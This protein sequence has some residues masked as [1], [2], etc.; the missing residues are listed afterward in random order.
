MSRR[1]SGSFGRSGSGSSHLTNGQDSNAPGAGGQAVYAVNPALFDNC[2]AL[3]NAP[4][5]LTTA[6]ILKVLQSSAN[7]TSISL[8]SWK[9]TAMTV[10]GLLESTAYA[11]FDVFFAFSGGCIQSTPAYTGGERTS[12]AQLRQESNRAL[13]EKMGGTVDQSRWPAASTARQVSLPGLLVFLLCQLFVER[14]RTTAAQGDSTASSSDVADYVR[15]HLH[16]FVTAV[17]VTRASRLTQ[18]DA[19]ELGYL[20]REVVNGVE[21]PFGPSVSFLWQYNE[22]TIDVAVLSQ[23]LRVRIRPNSEIKRGAASA[24]ANAFGFNNVTIQ[25][26]ANTV[27]ITPQ[28]LL[29]DMAT[30]LLS[31]NLTIANCSQTH[32][33]APSSLPHTQLSSLTNCTVSLGPVSGV[34]SI[35]NCHHCCVSALCGAV[36]VSGCSNLTLYICVNTPP[37]FLQGATA[38]QGGGATSSAQSGVRFAPYNSFYPAMEQHISNSGISPLLNFWNVGLPDHEAILPPSEFQSMPFPLTQSA[39]LSNVTRTNPCP[40]PA[41]YRDAMNR[42]LHRLREVNEAIGSACTKLRDAGRNDLVEDLH[43]RV[44][45]MFRDWLKESGQEHVLADLTHTPPPSKTPV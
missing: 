32:I 30:R 2:G 41:P 34:L 44:T 43:Q 11:V 29:P 42:R 23:Y 19:A 8:A 1:Q 4:T 14:K 27:H 6:T 37:V 26:L 36:V 33:Y 16:D 45:A 35:Q 3:L 24:A 38:D 10:L 25:D 5:G 21:Q 18:A 22:K 28:T 17:A 20:L 31:S 9:E 40:L 39:N 15:N 12:V 13:L 7:K